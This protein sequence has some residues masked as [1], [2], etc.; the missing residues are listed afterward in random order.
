M[1]AKGTKSAIEFAGRSEPRG[2]RW[3]DTNGARPWVLTAAGLGVLW[4]LMVL[5]LPV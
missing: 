2:R 5:H 1:Y 3:L 4:L